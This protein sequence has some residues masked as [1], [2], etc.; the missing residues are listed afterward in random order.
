M[1]EL[2][3][4]N[5]NFDEYIN[6]LPLNIENI[7]IKNQN[8]DYIP[9]LSRFTQ[10]KSLNL[11]FNKIKEIPDHFLPD[12]IEI[13]N[14]YQ[15]DLSCLPCELPNNLIN[16][17]ICHNRDL[18]HITS[19]PSKL[20]IMCC[21]YNK[22]PNFPPMPNSLKTLYICYNDHIETLPSLSENLVF[23]LL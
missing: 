18:S 20:E 11:S 12:S 6:G 9:N 4:T 23:V 17:C 5:F 22:F 10:L 19:L 1:S 2:I 13:L 14:L 3:N 8:I 21:Y 15:N 16:L 7:E